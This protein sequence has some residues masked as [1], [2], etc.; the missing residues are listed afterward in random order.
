MDSVIAKERALP[1][2]EA[3]EGHRNGD[4]DIDANHSDL[5]AVSEGAGGV[6]VAG[7][8]GSSVTELVFVDQL[9]CGF[10]GVGADDAEDLT[11]EFLANLLQRKALST[12]DRGRGRFRTFLLCSA[13]ATSLLLY[14]GK[15]SST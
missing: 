2:S 10:E 13:E 8:D 1:A 11:Q 12:A 4:R 7:E 3:V 14:G 15:L 5:D 6:S 9:E